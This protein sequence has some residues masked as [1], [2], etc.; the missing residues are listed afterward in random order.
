M[1]E[2]VHSMK[3]YKYGLLMALVVVVL[4]SPS[5]PFRLKTR[6]QMTGTSSPLQQIPSCF[7]W[8]RMPCFRSSIPLPTGSLEH[9]SRLPIPQQTV[10]L[11]AL[12]RRT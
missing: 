3:A 12:H 7:T 8:E 6:R 4:P 1:S 11:A 10:L 9:T 2:K 5:W